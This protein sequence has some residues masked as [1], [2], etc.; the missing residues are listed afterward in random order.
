MLSSA[1]TLWRRHRLLVSAFVLACA[2]ALFFAARFTVQAIYWANHRD[3]GIT[4]WMTLGYIAHSWQV[5]P[6]EIEARVGLPPPQGHP[7]PLVEL[8]GEQ[9]VTVAELITRIEAAIA[10][11]RAEEAAR[12]AAP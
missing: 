6:Q 12:R 3:E 7:K 8:A 9:H 4:P 11:I 5:R 2:L 1:F 10:A